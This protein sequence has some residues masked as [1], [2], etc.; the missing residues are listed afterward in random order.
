MWHAQNAAECMFNEWPRLH[1]Q[2][3]VLCQALEMRGF[4]HEEDMSDDLRHAKNDGEWM[5]RVRDI[6]L[7]L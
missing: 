2:P 1:S 5:S 7:E 3:C 4:S 6:C